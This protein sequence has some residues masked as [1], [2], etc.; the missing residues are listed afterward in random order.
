MEAAD[1]SIWTLV[2][3]NFKE[4]CTLV[5]VCSFLPIMRFLE[6]RV[7]PDVATLNELLKTDW[8]FR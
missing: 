6:G 3:C 7:L 1:S 4:Y 2:C 8:N 5:F